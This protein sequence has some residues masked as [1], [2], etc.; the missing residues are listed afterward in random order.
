MQGEGF[1]STVQYFTVQYL[2]HVEIE[3]AEKTGEGVSIKRL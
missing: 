3:N 2:L 1:L